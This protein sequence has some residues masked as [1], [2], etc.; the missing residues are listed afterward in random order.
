MEMRARAWQG[1]NCVSYSIHP[2]AA[3][4]LGDTAVYYATHASAMIA[5]ALVADGG[6]G[7]H[8]QAIALLKGET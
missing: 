8:V 7:G 4:E 3:A 1:K 5:L 2:D 6:H